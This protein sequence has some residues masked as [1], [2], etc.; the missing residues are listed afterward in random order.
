MMMIGCICS[1][2][3]FETSCW[4]GLHEVLPIVIAEGAECFRVCFHCLSGIVIITFEPLISH[5]NEPAD[6][7]EHGKLFWSGFG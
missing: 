2:D 5:T 6:A 7:G 3:I 1:C 4:E